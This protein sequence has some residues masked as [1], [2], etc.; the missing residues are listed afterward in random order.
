MVATYNNISLN[1]TKIE[2][3]THQEKLQRKFDLSNFGK[4]V[5]ICTAYNY[6]KQF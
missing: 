5:V 4:I 3:S 6:Y 1:K 2:T